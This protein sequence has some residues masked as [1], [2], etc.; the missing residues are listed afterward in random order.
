MFKRFGSYRWAVNTA[1]MVDWTTQSKFR[2]AFLA[3]QV[4]TYAYK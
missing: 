2:L 1:K 4:V 3:V